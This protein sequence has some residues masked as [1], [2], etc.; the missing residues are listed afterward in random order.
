MTDASKPDVEK[1]AEEKGDDE[2]AEN[3][4]GSNYLVKESTEFPLPS[5]SLLVS[6][7]F[8]STTVSPPQ[9]TPTIS[10]MQQTTTS[11]PTPPIT[12]EY[13]T[14]TTA[15]PKFDALTAVQLTVAKLEKD[16]SELK[17][18]NHSA[19]II[20][21]LKSQVPTV[22]DDYLGSKIGDA[23]QKALQ[24]HSEDLIQKH[25]MKPALES[26]KI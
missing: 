12:T 24:K 11:I 13:P 22:V 18:I 21:T 3:A 17:N 9:V 4:D 8:A 16:V 5:S 25:S 10:I 7:G 23:L 6:S 1:S 26:R 19:K 14:I 20:A 2:N 15:V